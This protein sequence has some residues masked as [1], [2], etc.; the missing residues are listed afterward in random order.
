MKVGILGFGRLGKLLTRN[1]SKDATTLVYDVELN[2]REVLEAG[3]TISS[4]EEICQCPILILCVP[5]SVIETIAKE[6]STLVTKDTLVVDVCS[7]KVHPMNLLMKALPEETE[8]L[9]THPMFGP[10]SAAKSLYGCKI[11]LCKQRIEEEK[12][13]N[14]KGYLESHGLKVIEATAHEHDKQIANSLILTHTIGRT[15]MDMQSK[16]ME[17][18]T[19]GYRRLLKILET[20]ENDSVQ[21]FKDMNK[22]NPYAKEMRESLSSSLERTLE[23]ALK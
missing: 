20:V 11:V 1:L 14:I 7:V 18:D 12:Y 13:K 16:E 23:S 10:D 2:E 6:I 21:L 22:Y 3:A 9:G 5:I 15:L 8:I 19:K 4:L 17:I